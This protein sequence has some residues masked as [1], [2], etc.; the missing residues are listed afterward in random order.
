MAQAVQPYPSAPSAQ[1]ASASAR[2]SIKN[3]YI[4]MGLY[5]VVDVLGMDIIFKYGEPVAG[6]KE[7]GESNRITKRA[8]LTNKS[9][10]NSDGPDDDWILIQFS[11][12]L[13]EEFQ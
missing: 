6:N 13:N 3:W 8:D 4:R 7:E 5:N 1:H 2:N 10:I 12:T 11:K 9:A